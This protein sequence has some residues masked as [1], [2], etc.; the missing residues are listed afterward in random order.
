MILYLSGTWTRRKLLNEVITSMST[1][2]KIRLLYSFLELRGRR[3]VPDYI[4]SYCSGLFVDSGAFSVYNS[5]KSIDIDEFCK[6]VITNRSHF[7]VVASLDVIGNWEESKKNYKYLIKQ[8]ADVLPCYH[9]GEPIDLLDWYTS[10]TDYVGIG[11]MVGINRRQR[12]S[13]LDSVFCRHPD[14]EKVKLHGFGVN[15]F[16]LLNKYPFYSVDSAA[17][18]L[19]AVNRQ[20]KT[21]KGVF[22]LGDQLY[23]DK[24]AKYNDSVREYVRELSIQYLGADYLEQLLSTNKHVCACYLILLMH[25]MIESK[26]FSSDYIYEKQKIGFDLT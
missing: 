18:V 6:F 2:T 20:L 3:Y 25:N 16:T 11:G 17:I 14:I 12:E 7:D 5:G 23:K 8:G 10:I 13:F 24:G 9:Y 1:T 26:K 21:D 22:Y 15:D 4:P 19:C